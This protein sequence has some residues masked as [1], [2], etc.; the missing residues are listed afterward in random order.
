MQSAWRLA[1]GLTKAIS[2]AK[3]RRCL[4]TNTAS[5]KVP[6]ASAEKFPNICLCGK[7]APTLLIDGSHNGVRSKLAKF[8][9]TPGRNRLET[10]VFGVKL[11]DCQ[12]TSAN[13]GHVRPRS[14]LGGRHRLCDQLVGA[15]NSYKQATR[16]EKRPHARDRTKCGQQQKYDLGATRGDTCNNRYCCNKTSATRASRRPSA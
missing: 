1:T 16:S 2:K 4:R 14:P 13:S 3:A 11:G 7:D 15:A 8:Q 12:P 5:R 6:V 9:A 10:D